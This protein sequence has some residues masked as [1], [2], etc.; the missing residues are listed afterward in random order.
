MSGYKIIIGRTE[1]IDIVDTVLRIP[2]KVDTGAYRSAI[3]CS[4]VEVVK[5][6]GQEVLQATLLGH[7]CSPVT[8]Q[9]TFSDFTKVTITNSFG[10]QEER[11]EVMLRVK[12]GPKVF[13][14]PF[15]LADRSGTLFPVL[16]GR[17]LLKGRFLIDVG[18]AGV[19][20]LKLKKEFGV[21]APFDEEDLE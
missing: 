10:Q 5:H 2:A 13:R 1:H 3:H 8:Y 9:R 21:A 15:T 19:D 18:R 17:K 11:Y 20:R 12:I 16:L 14:T 7:P 6:E 4:S